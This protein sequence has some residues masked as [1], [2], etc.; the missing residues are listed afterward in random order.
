MGFNFYKLWDGR[1]RFG[2]MES[3]YQNFDIQSLNYE[4]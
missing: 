4:K 3:Y 1:I 2:E